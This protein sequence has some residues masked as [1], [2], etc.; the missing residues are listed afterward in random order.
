MRICVGIDVAKKKSNVAFIKP[1]GE[2]EKEPYV[3]MHNKKHLKD[4]ADL[5]NSYGGKDEIRVVME[6]TG[7]YHW[8]VVKALQSEG[9]FVSTINPLKMK[10]FMADFNYR[11]PKT[12]NIDAIGIGNY[13]IEKWYRL[14]E[15]QSTDNV[16]RQ[17]RVMA[18]QYESFL[19]PHVL[20]TQHL[21]HLIDQ[22]MPGIKKE[23]KGYNSV[24]GKDYLSDFLEEFIHY[25]RITG[26]GEKKFTER[27]AKWAEKKGY[28]PRKDKAA[29][30]YQLAEEGIPTM[31]YD[32]VCRETVKAAVKALRSASEVLFD[33]LTRMRELAMTRPEYETV[34]AMGAVG[35]TLAPLLVAEV[36]NPA[37]YHSGDALIASTGIDV[38]PYESGQYSSKNRRIT[39]KGNGHLRRV[40]YLVVNSVAKVKPSK[41]PKVYEFYQKKLSEG[42]YTK[43]AKVAAMNKFL[44]IYYARTIAVY[45]ALENTESPSQDTA[46]LNS[47]SAPSADQVCMSA[48]LKV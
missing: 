8:P 14:R 23:L 33:I 16:Y 3:V 47:S 25:D 32:D 29:K 2:I 1:D 5:I 35:D 17:L 38:P 28:H 40:V 19:K 44:R 4:L 24:T 13:G 46:V 18:R 34:R 48:P 11:G 39:K 22:V 30:I 26:M 9:I 20:Y 42:K 43:V 31:D 21:D 36:G 7:S 27:F 10:K 6:E 15:H 45:K 41:D 37:Y 12:D